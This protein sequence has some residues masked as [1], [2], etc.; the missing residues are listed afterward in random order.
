VRNAGKERLVLESISASSPHFY[1]SFF[2]HT[3]LAP[4]ANTSF[5][6][7]FLA[8]AVGRARTALYINTSGGL[9]RY[10]VS[11]TGVRNRYGLYPVQGARVPLNSTYT[12]LIRL[13]NP[14]NHPL[15]VLEIYTSDDDL[16]LELPATFDAELSNDSTPASKRSSSTTTDNSSGSD[17][18]LFVKSKHNAINLSE[19]E[20]QNFNKNNNLSS[21][22][23][24][25]QQQQQTNKPD[26][27]R[28]ASR[29]SWYLNPFETKPVVFLRYMGHNANNHTAFLCIRTISFDS[30]PAS[31]GKPKPAANGL[32]EL[33]FVLPVDI[34]VT[35][36]PGLFASVDYL[37]FEY[38]TVRHV[39]TSERFSPALITSSLSN[40]P[41][42][43]FSPF[44]NDTFNVYDDS[45]RTV[46][47]FLSN[48][49]SSLVEI[50]EVSSVRQNSALKIKYIPGLVLPPN[51]NQ[52][53]KVAEVSF[54]G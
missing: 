24:Q 30:T 9:L 49:M 15:Q 50:K 42:A 35:A 14:T 21:A 45:E 53:T 11:G 38:F 39:T 52:L 40:S 6:V 26:K 25:Q 16:H 43:A 27:S 20:R 12:H 8:R 3:V 5:D 7:Y 44:V 54:N 47:L 31:K 22:K 41:A 19:Q 1:C 46:D 18:Q 13:H 37:N 33:S 17:E 36:R 2:A 28:L 48:T 29:N 34:E 4:G 32:V 10:S 51:S 23:Q